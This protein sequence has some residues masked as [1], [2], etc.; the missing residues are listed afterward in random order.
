MA[1]V[2]PAG[3]AGVSSGR[4]IMRDGRLPE[5]AA[6]SGAGWVIRAA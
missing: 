6:V 4:P 1:V 5:P 3:F 2:T